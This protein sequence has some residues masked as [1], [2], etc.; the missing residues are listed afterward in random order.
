MVTG[1]APSKCHKFTQR[2]EISKE[3]EVNIISN[4]LDQYDGIVVDW[5][6]TG[7]VVEQ[8]YLEKRSPICKRSPSPC[9]KKKKKADLAYVSVR[10]GLPS[11]FAGKKITKK[12]D[13][14]HAR[15]SA[16]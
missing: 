4:A 7:D 3:A 10:W 11:K 6:E 14:V 1:F 15:V 16:W 2:G 8:R 5:V 13:K 9:I 12:Y